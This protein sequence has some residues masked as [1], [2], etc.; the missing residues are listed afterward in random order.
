M[1][2]WMQQSLDRFRECG[3]ERVRRE[4]ASPAGTAL[5]WQG[6]DYL[7]FAS[8]DY[9]GL[10]CDSRLAH[11]GA[12][13]Y[14]TGAGSSPLITGW[15][16]PQQ[17]LERDLAD[18]HGTEAAL[19][20]SSGYATNIGVIPALCLAGDTIISDERNHASIIDGCRLSRATLRISR[21]NDI[22]HIRELL[23]QSPSGRRWIV[24]DSVFSMDGDLFPLADAL[25]LAREFD[26]AIV[27]D[28][29]H[30]TGVIGRSGEGL[31]GTVPR[32][33]R[34]I[35]VGTLSKSIGAQGGFVCSSRLV[36]DYLIHT[37]RSWIFSTSLAPPTAGAAIEGI[38]IIR[39]DRL[40]RERLWAN[41]RSLSE[42]LGIPPNPS[43]IFP[44]HIGRAQEAVRA[45]EALMEV[46]ILVPAIR[47]PT[48]PVDGCRLRISLSAAHSETD[49]RRLA[50]ALGSLKQDPGGEKV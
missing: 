20:F 40:L 39:Q 10:G 49:I 33:D 35:V 43:A 42:T 1:F 41:I 14:G 2:D 45:S 9:L 22:D 5:R 46:G 8:N 27:L 50:N 12:W 4:L 25:A 3:L 15:S 16:I 28:E 11:N 47:P 48:V 37:C 44:F 18:W 30:A 29:A 6:R 19:T 23:V 24:A 26:A 38:R 7:S 17:R 31:A 13:T 21:H 34:I 32:D 36:V